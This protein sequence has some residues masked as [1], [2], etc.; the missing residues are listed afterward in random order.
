MTARNIVCR[1]AVASLAV[2]AI[3]CATRPD[4]AAGVRREMLAFMEALNALDVE[5]MSVFFDDDMTAF[6]PTAQ[7]ELATGKQSIV[8]IFRTY[9]ET[10]RKQVSRTSLVP[11]DLRVVGEGNSAVVSFVVRGDSS[12]AR[13]T[14]V[15]RRGGARRE[16][17]IIH[18]HA[19]NFAR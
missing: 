4:D 12:T 17:R 8:A 6:V 10:T 3:G 16:W 14:F 9:A 1:V 15:W 13:R 2:W 19:S 18:L 11:E 7:P 5:A